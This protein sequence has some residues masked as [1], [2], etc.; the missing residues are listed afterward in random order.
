[1]TQNEN[2][3][4]LL[5]AHVDLEA[6]RYDTARAQ[7]EEL[8]A[9]GDEQALM[10]LGSMHERG[11]GGSIDEAAAAAC[12]RKSCDAG[13][14]TSCFF[15]GLLKFRNGDFESALEPYRTAADAGHPAAAYWIAQIYGD[16]TNPRADQVKET[17]YLEI[18]VRGGHAFAARDL[19]KAR[20]RKS[21]SIISKVHAF[22][23]YL[24]AII[25]GIVIIARNADDPRVQ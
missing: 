20:M 2:Y 11:L 23:Q 6:G 10:Y 17:H 22:G 7:F 4:R 18:A 14:A 9:L 16:R 12:Y 13:N 5:A 1:M 8:G 25:R 24:I 21:G 15:L 19:A 3:S